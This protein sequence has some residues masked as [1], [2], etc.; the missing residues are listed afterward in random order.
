ML[1]FCEDFDA[2][3]EAGAVRDGCLREEDEVEDAESPSLASSSSPS[4]SSPPKAF[5]ARDLLDEDEALDEDGAATAFLKPKLTFVGRAGEDMM[6]AQKGTETR[7]CNSTSIR[8]QLSWP[9]RCVEGWAASVASFL[10]LSHLGHSSCLD[11]EGAR[12]SEWL[13]TTGGH[14]KRKHAVKAQR[15]ARSSP[16]TSLPLRRSQQPMAA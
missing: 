3:A 6:V 15:D 8:D 14:H 10:S 4:S 11:L 12:Q 1:C 9:E 16:L 5:V 7:K 2:G 13:Q